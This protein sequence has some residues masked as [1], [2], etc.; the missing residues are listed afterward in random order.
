[1][2]TIRRVRALTRALGAALVLTAV[3]A[4]GADQDVSATEADRA[5]ELNAL[6]EPLGLKITPETAASLY[7]TDG[8]EVCKAA[9][10]PDALHPAG[11]LV[12]HR[13]PLRKVEVD[14][15]IAAY[16]RAVVAVYCPQNLERYDRFLADLAIEGRAG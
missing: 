13:F 2:A 8:G 1:M 11:V 5:A 16:S 15:E 12:S 6:A 10:D 4:G 7:G 3:A 14:R 9:E